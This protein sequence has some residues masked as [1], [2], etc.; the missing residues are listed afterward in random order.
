MFLKT[1][2]LTF[3]IVHTSIPSPHCYSN[4][5]QANYCGLRVLQL[6]ETTRNE[7]T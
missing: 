6:S 2:K 4:D 1:K 5:E 3:S 7:K